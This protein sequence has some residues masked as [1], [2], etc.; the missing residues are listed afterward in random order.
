MGSTLGGGIQITLERRISVRNLVTR[1]EWLCFKMDS[2]W[3]KTKVETSPG[4]LRLSEGLRLV[5]TE[6]TSSLRALK[7]DCRT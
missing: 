6:S 2:C 4:L 3:L 5:K 1:F 7:I